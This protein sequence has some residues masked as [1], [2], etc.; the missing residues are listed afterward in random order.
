[1]LDRV[2]YW[3]FRLTIVLTRPLP[4]R[5]GYRVAGSVSAVCYRTIF[6]AHR[7]ALMANLAHVLD[8]DDAGLLDRV[9]ARSFQNFGKYVIDFIHFPSLTRNE[10]QRRL[11]F[12]QWDELNAAAG[13]GRGIIIATLHFGN[14][15]LGAA[16][17]A[18][19]D[20]KIN[21][22][23]ETFPYPPM[24][25]LVQGSR[26]KLGLRFIGSERTGPA[27]FRALRRGEMLAILVDVVTDE[28][29]I[30]VEFF[31]ASARVS[32]AAARIALRTN[33]WVIP[34]IVAR[35]ATDD[36]AIAPVLDFSLR[37]FIASG[38][39]ATD[40]RELTQRIMASME[41]HVRAH[42]DQWFMYRPMWV[43]T[44]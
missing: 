5:L 25:E 23:A 19:Y 4:L 22:V 35:D 15:D 30:E 1:V 16:A 42:P 21:A 24:N 6:R 37:D 27:V 20:Y 31:G 36:M 10:M 43:S 44:N 7:K 29:S 8:S 32:A 13:S 3:L 33:A 34:A 41:P 9:G 17:L 2:V 11:R 39:E 26:A 40:A 14:W 28:G 12:D 18:A 38:D